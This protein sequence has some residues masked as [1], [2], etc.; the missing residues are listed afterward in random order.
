[1]RIVLVRCPRC[2]Q[3]MIFKTP[4]GFL[5]SSR[6]VEATRGNGMITKA[7]CRRCRTW[8]EVSEAKLR[9]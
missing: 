8:V 6:A 3:P 1:M 5:I 2:K 4:N 7:K 9:A